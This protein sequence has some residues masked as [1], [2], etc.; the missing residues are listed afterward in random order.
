MENGRRYKKAI[1]TSIKETQKL[2]LQKSILQFNLI[3]I[4]FD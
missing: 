2:K 4:C 3:R 1:Y